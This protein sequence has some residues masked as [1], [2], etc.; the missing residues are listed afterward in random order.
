MLQVYE[1]AYRLYVVTSKYVKC[2]RVETS[3]SRLVLQ[4]NFIVTVELS[5]KRKVILSNV[6]QKC[7]PLPPGSVVNLNKLNLIEIELFIK[8]LYGVWS[9]LQP[10]HE[11]N[12]SPRRMQVS[13]PARNDDRSPI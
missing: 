2:L 11:T 3:C 7:G 5:V 13:P 4:L 12:K 8:M 6:K 10:D 9:S 1:R